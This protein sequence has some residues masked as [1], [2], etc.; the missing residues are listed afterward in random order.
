MALKYLRDNLRHLKFVLWGV[1]I[2]FVLLVFVDWGSGRAGGGGNGAAVKIGRHEVTEQQFVQQVKRL[3]DLYQRQ[4]GDNWEQFKDRINLGEQAVQQLVERQLLLDEAHDMGLVVSE[5]EVRRQVLS[6]PVFTDENGQFIGQ[7]GYKRILRANRTNPQDF[8]AQL[9]EDLLLEKLRAMLVDGIWI[10]DAE[11]DDSIRRER[12][13]ASVK[14]IQ[15]RY[16]RFLAD[17]TIGDDEAREYFEANKETFRREEERVI[18][19]LVIET[20]KLRRLLEVD[21]DQLQAYFDEHKDEFRQ[22]E[23]V[24]ASHILFRLN[25]GATPDEEAAVKLKAEQVAKL[26][27]GGADFAELAGVHSEDPG[28]KDNGGDLGWFGK[29]RM[30]PE[31]EKAVFGAKPGDLIGPVKSQFGYHVIKVVGVRPERV[32]SLDEIKDEVRFKYLESHAASEAEVRAAA[33]AKRVTTERPDTDEAWQ[34]IADEDEAVVL[35]ESPPFTAEDIIPGTGSDPAFTEEVFKADVGDIGGPKVI[36]RGWIVWQ[37]KETRPEGIP[38]FEIARDEVEQRL[39][40]EKAMALAEEKAGELAAAWK[41]GEDPK[42]LAEANDTTVVEAPNHRRG[43]AFGALGVVPAL[44]AEVFS[45]GEG[46]VIG[47]VTVPERGVIV[48]RVERLTLVSPEELAAQ[49]EQKRRQLMNQRADQLMTALVNERRRETTV[50]VNTE[51]V[52][53]FAPKG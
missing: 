1:V 3:Q 10:D 2:V 51:L 47:P 6:L 36:P 22:G 15:L 31:F 21:D 14:A 39:G 53:Q 17:V 8:E 35:N 37:L 4:L 49:R 45:A 19:Y 30:V 34:A 20:N 38:D 11:V 42:T 18:R 46:D 13:Q 24:Q 27:R 40:R 52:A 32:P 23:Q 33:L 25:P 5:E 41:A 9:R 26:A 48:A 7:E 44:D 29:G 43:A 28:S 16:E 12:E 50:T